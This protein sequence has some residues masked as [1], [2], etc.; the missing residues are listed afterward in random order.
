MSIY[1]NIKSN[2][3][4]GMLKLTSDRDII[5]EAE[6]RKNGNG[7][8]VQ[9]HEKSMVSVDIGQWKSAIQMALNQEEPDR[10]QLYQVYDNIMIDNHLSSIVQS[11]ILRVEGSPFKIVNKEGEENIE[12]TQLF[13]KAW[14][15]EFLKHT[16]SSRF[17]GSTLLELVYNENGMQRC[18]IVPRENCN[19]KKKVIYL[20]PDDEK[21]INYIKPPLMNTIIEVG[22]FNDLGL[23]KKAAPI[24][25]AKK[26]A[27]G[28][29]SEYT[30]KFGIPFRWIT[31]DGHDS[32]RTK[33]LGTIMANMGGTG[34]GVFKKGEEINIMDT[35]GT[36]AHEIFDSLIERTNKEMSKL[37][38]GQTMTTDD[39][40]SHSQAEV[41]R[42][43]A[44]DRHLSD[45]KFVKNVINDLLLPRLNLLG[46]G[47]FEGYLFD[48]DLTEELSLTNLIESISKLGN[49][50]QIDLDYITEKTGIP[51]LGYRN[52]TIEE[53]EKKKIEPKQIAYSITIPTMEVDR[54]CDSDFPLMK[55]SKLS[56]V[57]DQLLKDVHDGKAQLNSQTY[58]NYLKD[59]YM[60]N[61]NK[62]FSDVKNIDYNKPDHIAKAFMEANITRFSASKDLAMVNE[63]NHILN[64]S[65]SFREFKENAKPILKEFNG[66][67]LKTE[68]EFARSVAQNASRYYRQMD[69]IEE[70]P[71]YVYKTVGDNRVRQAHSSLHNQVFR[72]DD[73]I[74][75]AIYPPNGWGC[76]CELVETSVIPKGRKV[77]TGNNAKQ[78]LQTSSI[79]NN[80][81]SE[82]DRMTQGKFNVNRGVLKTVFDQNKMYVKGNFEQSFSIENNGLKKF[83]E[84]NKTQ[85]KNI[86]VKET[87]KQEATKWFED[88]V[89]E[90]D[91]DDANNIR[92]TD[93]SN[94]PLTINKKNFI[95]HLKDDRANYVEFIDDVINNPDEVYLINQGYDKFGYRYIKYYGG[96]TLNVY[97]VFDNKKSLIDIRSW[98]PLDNHID[99]KRVGLLVKKSNYK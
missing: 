18:S 72:K 87:S 28:S 40:S 29:W 65:N 11:R 10:I 7:L 94:K 96:Q 51:I 88:R 57:E 99:A 3:I 35:P 56:N 46:I 30:E 79:D 32:N 55:S 27:L 85:F 69:N 97:A 82:W 4:G 6:S 21:G 9:P 67:H 86:T 36:S 66:N 78:I 84:I 16:I 1:Q 25:L 73:A 90:N 52:E 61:L 38:L 91:L 75:N 5:V 8:D 92:L 50:Y 77:I 63:L 74:V 53:P 2:I 14:F 76:R 93:F 58:F 15:E 70:L 13:E 39:G 12:L 45:K 23:L 26:Y 41:H 49:T 22:N 24:A 60:K 20:N 33:K 34:W 64:D 81:L 68:Y 47:N 44:E 31:T 43:V 98:H 62:G 80:G 48:W 37:I 71:Y 42:Q 19:F 17:W 95:K 59:E 54:C 83:E 89:G